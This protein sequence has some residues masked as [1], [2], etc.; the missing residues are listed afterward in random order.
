MKLE[1]FAAIIVEVVDPKQLRMDKD[2]EEV[3]RQASWRT[4]TDSPYGEH[5]YI[6]C[7][8]KGREYYSELDNDLR[9]IAVI[10]N[11]NRIFIAVKWTIG[12]MEGGSYTGQEAYAINYSEPEPEM[13]L[14]KVL[15]RV[16]PNISFLEY[17]RI[18]RECIEQGDHR[19]SEYYGNYENQR[20]KKCRLDKLFKHLKAIKAI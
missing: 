4:E 9:K 13:D 6:K 2:E 18:L 16:A 11:W 1:E 12:G 8:K 19:E 20:F 5:F 3:E 17:K 10:E 14:D 7:K 15:E